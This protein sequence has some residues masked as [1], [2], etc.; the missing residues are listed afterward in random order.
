MGL[1]K[2]TEPFKVFVLRNIA[3]NSSPGRQSDIATLRKMLLTL[4]KIL[5][6]ALV[7]GPAERFR[8]A[9]RRSICCYIQYDPGFGSA[10]NTDSS[11]NHK[12]MTPR[13]HQSS[14][15][16]AIGRCLKRHVI[17]WSLHSQII[18][19]A[20]GR[21]VYSWSTERDRYASYCR[22]NTSPSKAY[23]HMYSKGCPL[24]F[25]GCVRSPYVIVDLDT[26][27]TVS[28]A[29]LVKNTAW[30]A[31]PGFDQAGENHGDC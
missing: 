6:H 29:I 15:G 19:L 27:P 8:Y 4:R 13:Y 10:I 17:H 22:T 11:M 5:A 3:N 18:C 1:L 16:R 30:E 14:R 2:S 24:A 25:R 23:N 28:L 7:R 26:D 20:I 12:A 21:L 9:G 31:R